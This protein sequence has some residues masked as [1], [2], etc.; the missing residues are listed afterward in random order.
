MLNR[1]GE[2]GQGPPAEVCGLPS[3]AAL[4]TWAPSATPR[5]WAPDTAARHH[6]PRRVSTP[7]NAVFAACP[8][9]P[10]PA[11]ARRCREGGG[12][13]SST[14]GMLSAWDQA[15][16]HFILPSWKTQDVS[17]HSLSQYLFTLFVVFKSQREVCLVDTAV[18]VSETLS[19]GTVYKSVSCISSIKRWSGHYIPS[20]RPIAALS[21]WEEWEA[22][23]RCEAK[24]QQHP[25]ACSPP[26]RLLL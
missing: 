24:G 4:R 8:R 18:I 11:P 21:C 6:S 23:E 1:T 20:G 13:G 9:C 16:W 10:C 2:K 12:G 7:A 5:K 17:L 15:M 14:L 26:F 19:I 3:Q 25:T 22:R